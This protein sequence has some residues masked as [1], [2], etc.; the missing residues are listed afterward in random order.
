MVGSNHEFAKSI[1]FRV[2]MLQSFRYDGAALR[3]FEDAGTCSLIEPVL[4]NFSKTFM[5][6]TF[7]VIGPRVGVTAKPFVTPLLPRI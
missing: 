4:H 1:A 2:E 5:V 3:N 6:L 7:L